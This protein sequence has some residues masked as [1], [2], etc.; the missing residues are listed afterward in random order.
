MIMRLLADERWWRLKM[1]KSFGAASVFL[2]E[3]GTRLSRVAVCRPLSC[4]Y[5]AFV[6]VHWFNDN[7]IEFVVLSSIGYFFP[8]QV[9]WRFM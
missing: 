1:G 4:A 3:S 6:A 2:A 5:P 9:C 8:C 7:N